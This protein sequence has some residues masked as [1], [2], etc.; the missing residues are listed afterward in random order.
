MIP[1]PG[2]ACIM[3]GIVQLNDKKNMELLIADDEIHM[4]G[5]DL[6]EIFH[7]VLL[8]CYC[9][10]VFYANL[11]TDDAVIFLGSLPEKHIKFVFALC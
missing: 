9:Q 10:K 1:L 7:V 6:A 3:A 2:I 11:R 5:G 8:V 4:L